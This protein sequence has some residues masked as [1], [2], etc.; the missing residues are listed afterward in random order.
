MRRCIGSDKVPTV[1]TAHFAKFQNKESVRRV[2]LG[3]K[4]RTCSVK[5][6]RGVYVL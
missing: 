1:R 2:L 6:G 5:E 3:N 4:S